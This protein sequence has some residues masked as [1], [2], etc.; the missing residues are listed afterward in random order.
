MNPESLLQGLANLGPAL[1]AVVVIG[2]ICW[3]LL[4]MFDKHGDAINKIS[5][6][7]KEVDRS[8]QANTKATE[9]M[10]EMLRRGL[11]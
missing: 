8:V 1:G 4:Q 2:I 3:K 6:T 9:C 10:A 7:M 5:Q 11:H